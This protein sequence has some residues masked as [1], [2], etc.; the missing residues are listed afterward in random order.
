MT[1]EVPQSFLFSD[2]IY[3]LRLE[4]LRFYLLYRVPYLISNYFCD[5]DIIFLLSLMKTSF[6]YLC[7][8]NHAKVK[9]QCHATYGMTNLTG[10][11]MMY[12]FTM[13]ITTTTNALLQQHGN[14]MALILDC[15]KPFYII[16]VFLKLYL[17]NSNQVPKLIIYSPKLN[18]SSVSIFISYLCLSSYLEKQ[19]YIFFHIKNYRCESLLF[20]AGSIWCLP[21]HK[22][23]SLSKWFALHKQ[24]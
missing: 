1:T 10:V 18:S 5:G 12:F 16:Y 3:L 19:T 6:Y 9:F 8:V 23:I 13:G 4:P 15:Y 17:K 11:L 14:L 21:Y 24:A 7:A 20:R 22:I 2:Y